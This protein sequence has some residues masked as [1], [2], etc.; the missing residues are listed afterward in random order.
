MGIEFSDNE[1]ICLEIN[2]V[3]AFIKKEMLKEEKRCKKW[4]KELQHA[5]KTQNNRMTAYPQFCVIEEVPLNTYTYDDRDLRTIDIMREI[6]FTNKEALEYIEKNNDGYSG[7]LF[8]YIKSG[9]KNKG[10][11]AVIDCILSLDLDKYKEREG[12]EEVR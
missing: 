6:F 1:M 2:D 10:W 12:A 7:D 8:I 5:L 3:D 11:K 4:L 9:R